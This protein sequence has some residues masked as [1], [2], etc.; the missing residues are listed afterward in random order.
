[1]PELLQGMRIRYG[2]IG[3]R[4]GR[5]RRIPALKRPSYQRQYPSG[6][7][8]YGRPCRDI[9]DNKRTRGNKRAVAY[10]DRTE[11]TRVHTYKYVVAYISPAGFSS[12]TDR[13]YMMQRTIC[14][15]PCSFSHS[16][17]GAVRD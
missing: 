2:L 6:N 5:I 15:Y 3:N 10:S 7:A 12:C 17:L 16:Y 1:M 14:T 4:S 9:L 13:A 11:D 8:D